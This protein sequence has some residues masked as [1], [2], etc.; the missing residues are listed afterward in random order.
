MNQ[1]RVRV[2]KSRKHDTAASI[3]LL[4]VTCQRMGFDFLSR[5]RRRRSVHRAASSAPFLTMPTSAQASPRRGAAPRKVRIC[6]VPVMSKMVFKARILCRMTTRRDECYPRMW[7]GSKRNNQR[8]NLR[9]LAL[10]N[11]SFSRKRWLP[12]IPRRH[13]APHQCLGRW[14]ARA[15]YAPP[16]PSCRPPP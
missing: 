12:D 9:A 7:S 4:R 6:D 10:S 1:V 15:Q 16:F 11:W 14:S 3:Q 2:H 8:G 5:A 13:G